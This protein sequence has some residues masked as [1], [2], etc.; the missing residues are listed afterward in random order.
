MNILT[1]TIG[2]AEIPNKISLNIFAVGCSHNCSGCHLPELQ[3]FNHPNRYYLTKEILQ[4]EIDKNKELIDSVCW[5]GGDAVFQLDQLIELSTFIKQNYN[6]V[7]CIYTGY[8]FEEVQQMSNLLDYVDILV[9]GKWEGKPISDP[10]TNQ[11]I[12]LKQY[13]KW[14]SITHKELFKC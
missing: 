12:Y 8:L 2:F 3:N 7:N 4:K 5:L 14:N 6:L 10:N 11:K 13:N 1:T 9:D